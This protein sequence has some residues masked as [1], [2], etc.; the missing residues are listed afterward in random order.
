MML[1]SVSILKSF[2]KNANVF[3]WALHVTP[4]GLRHHYNYRKIILDSIIVR[5]GCGFT[6]IEAKISLF[7]VANG[8]IKKLAFS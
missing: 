2:T 7:I 4:A 5:G 8:Y 3:A 1:N 6:F